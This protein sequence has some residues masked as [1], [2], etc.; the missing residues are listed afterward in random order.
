MTYEF[1]P[2][3]YILAETVDMQGDRRLSL[4]IAAV[5]AGIAVVM[6]LAAVFFFPFSDFI[7]FAHPNASDVWRLLLLVPSIFA[8]MALHELVHGLFMR[9]LSRKAPKFGFSGLYMYAESPVFFDRKSFA[10]VCTAPFVLFF[11]LFLVI[12]LFV[13]NRLFWFFHILQIINAGS[14]AGDFYCVLQAKKHPETTLFRINGY[15]TEIYR[16]AEIIKEQ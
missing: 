4:K 2:H 14:S 12:S 6:V 8:Y 7:S 3:G 1:L 10:C 9:I 5:Q 11:L 15:K 13:P 16:E